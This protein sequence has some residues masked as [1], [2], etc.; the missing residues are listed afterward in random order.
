M[1][2]GATAGPVKD[3]LGQIAKIAQL[4]ADQEVEL[5]KRIEAGLFAEEKLKAPGKI[6]SELNG[7]LEWISQEGRNARNQLLEAN[8]RLVVSLAQGHTGR[9]VLFLDLI[10]EG[11]LGLIYAVQKFDYTEGFKVSSHATW[12]V[13]QAITRAIVRQA[14][15]IRLPQ[16]M[17]ELINRVAVYER[18]AKV[19]VGHLPTVAEIAAE[20]DLAAR[21]VVEIQS[22]RR[23]PVSLHELI[24]VDWDEIASTSEFTGSGWATELGNLIEDFDAVPPG[25]AVNFTLLQE[26]LYSVLGTLSEREAGVVSMRYGLTDGAPKT[27]GEIGEVYGGVTRERIA[28]TLTW[29]ISKMRHPSRSQNLRNHLAIES[30]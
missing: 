23:R 13:H 5:A 14:R 30:P 6:D 20:L 2:A 4:D 19:H 17:V 9:G 18:W 26:H 25:D 7:E 15:T 28:H 1:T 16:Q 11:N 27:L 24:P 3:Y 10:Q 21:S 29:T 12:W 8:L 22:C